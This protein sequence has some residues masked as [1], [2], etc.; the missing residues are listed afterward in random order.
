MLTLTDLTPPRWIVKVVDTD[1][2]NLASAAG[3]IEDALNHAVAEGLTNLH[4]VPARQHYSMPDDRGSY[5]DFHYTEVGYL[6][7][8]ERR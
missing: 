4:V 5:R 3:A 2:V 7:I 6:V 1:D 8:G